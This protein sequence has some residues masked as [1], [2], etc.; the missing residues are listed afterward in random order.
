MS[1]KYQF[2]YILL[3]LLIVLSCKS[4]YKEKVF[5]NFSPVPNIINKKIKFPEKMNLF[6]KDSIVV[7]DSLYFQNNQ[8]KIIHLV[9]LDCSNCKEDL[10]IWKDLLAD[11][12]ECNVIFWLNNTSDKEMLIKDLCNEFD[13]EY[14]VSEINGCFECINDFVYPNIDFNTILLD[15]KNKVKLI[16]DPINNRKLISEYINEIKRIKDFED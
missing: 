2:I 7:I 13:T 15:K 5:E 16:G 6:T 4:E 14:F 3:F 8:I 11:F 9:N 10:L 1:N 12:Y